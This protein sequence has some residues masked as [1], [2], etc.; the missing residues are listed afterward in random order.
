MFCQFDMIAKFLT[1]DIEENEV[2]AQLKSELTH[3][4]N[5]YTYKYIPSKFSLKKQNFT[6]IMI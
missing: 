4:A 5:C 2:S 3:L 6:K 1:K